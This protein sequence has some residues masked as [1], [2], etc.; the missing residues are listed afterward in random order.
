M[1]KV[2]IAQLAD[3]YN[4]TVED[5]L[6]L[7]NDK[8]SDEMMTGK[9]KATW[10]NEEGQNILK[11]AAHIPECVPKHYEGKVIKSAANPNYIYA[12]IK[13]MDKKVPVMVP[14]RWRGRLR[15]KNILIEA[16]Q[17]VNGTS[18]RYRERHHIK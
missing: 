11:E 7:A 4:V 5:L 3:E 15:G 2:R 8:L 1:A 14:R 13:E 6:S 9:M 10:I 17:D 12:F 18:Y 16:I